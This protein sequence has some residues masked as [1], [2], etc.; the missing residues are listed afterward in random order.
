MRLLKGLK[1][2]YESCG[3]RGVLAASSFRIFGRPRVLKII[4]PGCDAAVFLRLNT[5]DFCAY[6]DVLVIRDKQYLPLEQDFSPRT[7]VD[8]GAHIGMASI[9][10][11]KKYPGAKIIALEPEPS[12]FAVL[13]RNTSAYRAIIP[14]QAALWNENGT[15]MLGKSSAHPKGAFQVVEIGGVKVRSM[16]MEMLMDETG[17]KSIDLLKVDIEGAEKKVFENC[18]WLKHVSVL[19]IELH[20]RIEPGCRRAIETAAEGFSSYELGEISFFTRQ[21]KLFMTLPGT[22]PV[23]A[24]ASIAEQR[25]PETSL[26]GSNMPT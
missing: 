11:A 8:A 15:V 21:L 3:L 12:N 4:P 6:R 23:A 19:A 7:I 16:T 22:G 24:V 17:I 10:F 9:L 25:E 1:W 20:D 2:Y 14:V 13:V 5:S 26:P 18:G